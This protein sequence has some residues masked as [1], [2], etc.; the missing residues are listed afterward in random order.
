MLSRSGRRSW[1]NFWM[2]KDRERPRLGGAAMT[3][4]HRT[5][6]RLNYEKLPF[7]A[8]LLAAVASVAFSQRAASQQNSAAA[9]TGTEIAPRGQRE[10]RDVTYGDWKKLCFK[11]G[12]AKMLCRTSIASKFA[13]GQ[14]AVRLAIIEHESD[15]STRVHV[16][17]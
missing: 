6:P 3:G 5:K 14:M 9:P 13:T 8:L 16:F 11:P 10:V 1:R 15:G 12:G 2:N 7:R 4:S 17:Y